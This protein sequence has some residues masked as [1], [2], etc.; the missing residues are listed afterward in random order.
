MESFDLAPHGIREKG[1]G[2]LEDA[3][4]QSDLESKYI[5]LYSI[6]ATYARRTWRCME[7]RGVSVFRLI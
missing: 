2:L 5:G 3:T 1:I 7:A 6:L 4:M